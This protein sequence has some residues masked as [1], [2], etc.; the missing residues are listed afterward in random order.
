MSDLLQKL[1]RTLI[2]SNNKSTSDP[3]K[4]EHN[5]SSE[6]TGGYHTSCR[7]NALIRKYILISMISDKMHQVC[8]KSLYFYKMCVYRFGSLLTI[9]PFTLFICRS[10]VQQTGRSL[11]TTR[12]RYRTRRA[13]WARKHS[14]WRKCAHSAYPRKYLTVLEATRTSTP[15]PSIHYYTIDPPIC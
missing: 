11:R 15:P 12:T 4:Q 14:S 10:R 2:M 9:E 6:E 3:T 8:A 7:T 1:F 13:N 5:L